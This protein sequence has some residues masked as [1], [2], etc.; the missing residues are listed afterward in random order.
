MARKKSSECTK[1]D[2]SDCVDLIGC[3]TYKRKNKK[4]CRSLPSRAV[5]Q[6]K[7]HMG[8]RGGKYYISKGRKVYVK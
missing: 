5:S 3:T 7:I 8:P 2:H 1:L 4:L 6:R